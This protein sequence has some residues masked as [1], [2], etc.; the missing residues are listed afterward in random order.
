METNP[1]KHITFP[2]GVYRQQI[3]M[4]N[5][6]IHFHRI[7]LKIRD[8]VVS[9]TSTMNSSHSLTNLEFEIEFCL[10]SDFSIS[11]VEQFDGNFRIV[12]LEVQGSAPRTR[13]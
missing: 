12:G 13:T 11:Y 9:D 4:N 5:L 6:F 7:Q 1:N 8:P 2:V 3:Q 10:H